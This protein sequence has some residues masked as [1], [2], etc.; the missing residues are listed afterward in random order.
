MAGARAITLDLWRTLV[1]E[2]PSTRNSSGRARNDR[3]IEGVSTALAAAGSPVERSVLEAAFRRVRDDID[4]AHH[5]GVDRTFPLWVRQVIEYA[6]PG[7]FDRLDASHSDAVLHAVDDPFLAHPPE[8]HP[9][10]RNVL[11]ELSGRNV[12]IALIS[13]T[14]FTSGDTYRRWFNWIGW[15][16]YFDVITFSNEVG[17]AKPTD[18]I[19]LSTLKELGAAPEDSIHVGDSHHS[20]ID[21]A[22]AVGMSTAW[23]SGFDESRPE[24]RPDYSL[25]DLAQLPAVIDRWLAGG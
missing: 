5:N 3:R 10:A 20:D 15:L 4:H 24:V 21:G 12:R 8:P 25:D 17:M 19:F 11:D 23:I 2:E 18:A 6:E 7:S 9:A 14:G 1:I 22:R 16:G 13:N